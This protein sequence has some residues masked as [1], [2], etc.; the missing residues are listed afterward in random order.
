MILFVIDYT[1]G[2]GLVNDMLG[3]TIEN[4][5][6]SGS[7]TVTGLADKNHDVGGVIGQ[8]YDTETEA[9]VTNIKNSTSSATTSSKVIVPSGAE[10]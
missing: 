5:H 4:V 3:G 2:N 9:A 1:F 10:T 7:V 8:H 6:V